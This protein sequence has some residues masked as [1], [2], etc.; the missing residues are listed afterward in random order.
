METDFVARVCRLAIRYGSGFDQVGIG[1]RN[2]TV[3]LLVVR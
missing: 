2:A 1:H 3:R